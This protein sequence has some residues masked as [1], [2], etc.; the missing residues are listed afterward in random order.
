M[1]LR[2]KIFYSRRN[3]NDPRIKHQSCL[4]STKLKSIVFKVKSV[5]LGGTDRHA[6]IY[7]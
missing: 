5:L 3:V 1:D 4:K 2:K 7:L 6:R